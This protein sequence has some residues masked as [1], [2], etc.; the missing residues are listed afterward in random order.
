[1]LHAD[2]ILD[3]TVLDATDLH[4]SDLGRTTYYVRKSREGMLAWNP[5]SDCGAVHDW[6][7]LPCLKGGKKHDLHSCTYIIECIANSN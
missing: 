3:A 7:G 1:M 6:S 4:A 2:L 5:N